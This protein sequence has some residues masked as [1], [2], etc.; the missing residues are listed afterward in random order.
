MYGLRNQDNYTGVSPYAYV[1]STGRYR[2]A[3]DEFSWALDVSEESADLTY[4]RFSCSKCHNPHASRLPRL[5]ITNCLDISHNKWD[6]QSVSNSRWSNWENQG[7]MPY[8][9]NDISGDPVN[10]QLSYATSAQNCHRYVDVNGDGNPDEVGWNRVT[11]WSE[12]GSNFS[13]K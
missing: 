10:R 6:N 1:E 12:S 9:G 4:H 13:N 5:M 8:S 7:V 2:S 3:Y 11:P